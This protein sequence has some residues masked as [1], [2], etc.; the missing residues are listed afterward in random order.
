[1][2][3]GIGGGNYESTAVKRRLAL[4]GQSGWVS[5]AQLLHIQISAFT[6]YVQSGLVH[7]RKVFAIAVFASL[8][9]L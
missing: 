6:T 9:G 4:Q 5:S 7:N 2:G 3:G 1:M 8:G